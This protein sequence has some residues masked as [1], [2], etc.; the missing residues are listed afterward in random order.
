MDKSA[1]G[2]ATNGTLRSRDHLAVVE[3]Y[4][5]A[6]LCGV[7][8]IDIVEIRPRTSVNVCPKC[9]RAARKLGVEWFDVGIENDLY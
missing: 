2:W 5:T 7:G 6:A 1:L 9:I 3:P 4:Q 8:I